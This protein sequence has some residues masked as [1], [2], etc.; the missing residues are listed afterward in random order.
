[1]SKKHQRKTYYIKNSAQSK[2]INRFV[3]ISLI[4]GI[5]AVCAFN[6][7]AYKKIDSVLY[8]MRVP[9]TSASDM[10]WN[11]MLYTNVFVILFILIVFAITA[12]GLYNRVHG[13]LKKLTND[14]LRTESGDLSREISLR[15][16]DEFL[17]F[18]AELNTMVKDLNDRFVNVQASN[19][20]I[21]DNAKM[22]HET[23]DKESVISEIKKSI[24]NLEESIGSFKV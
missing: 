22:L 1:M 14:L 8:S 4:G 18:A 9:K 5:L 10:L 24:N 13:P 7:L 21:I 12:K 16:N 23:N 17:E 19:K 3:L 11:E 20:E 2:F 6:F 15:Q